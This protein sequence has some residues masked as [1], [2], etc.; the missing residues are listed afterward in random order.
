[1]LK[2]DQ[3]K[4]ALI[5]SQYKGIIDQ[6]M[7]FEN[8]DLPSCPHCLSDN[9][10]D[11]QV[12][13]IGRTICIAGATTKFRLIPNL[14]KPGRYYC[15]DCGKYFGEVDSKSGGFTLR[16]TDRS[17]QAYKAF[18]SGISEA[19]VPEKNKQELSEAQWLD[20]WR[21]FWSLPQDTRPEDVKE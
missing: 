17:F 12:G 20:N 10:A 11:V 13:V 4:L 15:H 18:I 19:V 7:R 5:E 16:P 1:M 2:L 21:K 8:A 6:I 3:G 14:P 9:T